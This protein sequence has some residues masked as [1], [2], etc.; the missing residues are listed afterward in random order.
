MEMMNIL[1]SVVGLLVAAIPA[2]LAYKLFTSAVDTKHAHM[3]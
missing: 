1:L 2:Y 3:R